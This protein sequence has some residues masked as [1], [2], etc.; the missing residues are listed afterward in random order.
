MMILDSGLLFLGPPC[1]VSLRLLKSASV[2]RRSCDPFARTVDINSDLHRV[3]A[4]KAG[5]DY[6]R[7]GTWV[8][9]TQGRIHK[10]TGKRHTREN[11]M[12]KY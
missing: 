10:N 12:L 6:T 7:T 3:N 9:C 1:R 11:I 5:E 8:L 4:A 2:P